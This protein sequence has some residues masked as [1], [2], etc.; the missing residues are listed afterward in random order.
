MAA[1]PSISAR[2]TGSESLNSGTHFSVLEVQQSGEDG[3]EETW[4]EFLYSF[5]PFKRPIIRQVTG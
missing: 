1:G 5:Q 3:K 4:R 2:L